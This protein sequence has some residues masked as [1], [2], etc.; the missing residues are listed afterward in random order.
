MTETIKKELITIAQVR[1]ILEKVKPDDMDQIQR[2]THDYTTKFAKT[3]GKQAQ[4]MVKQLVEQ[5]DLTQEEAVEV[6][7][8]M[9]QT[10]EELRAFTFGWKKL[11]L[12]ETLEKILAILKDES[13]A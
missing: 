13:Q 8:V 6:V 10:L 4:K 2:W 9:P 7:N 12:T 3:T 1:D 5:C 11:I